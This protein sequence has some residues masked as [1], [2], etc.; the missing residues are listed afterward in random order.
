MK[1]KH[2]LL[3]VFVLL[4][5]SLFL[6]AQTQKARKISEKDLPEIYR[7]WLK[8][9]SYI[10]LPVEKEVF[11]KL[12]SDR[13]R[14]IFIET[15]WK[16]RDPTPGTPENEY[17]DEHFKRFAHANKFFGRSSTRE[18]WQTDMGRIHIILGT[19]VSIERFEATS[20]IVPCQAWSYYGNPEKDLPPHFVLLFYQ[21]GGA[22][23]YRLYDPVSD[24]PAALLL[25]KRDIDPLDYYELYEKIREIA[26]TLAD[27]SISIVP[28]EFNPDYTPSPRNNMIM[29]SIFES[30]RKDVN[31]TY[32]TH[33][34]SYKGIVSTEYMTNYVECDSN[35]SLIEDP[36]TGIP[37]VHFSMAP[38]SMSIDYYEPKDQYYC[39][40]RL[41]VSLRDGEK[42]ILQY[43]R[44]F[45]IY[46]TEKDTG[47]IQANGIAIEDSF[48]AA[49]GRHRLI[50]LLQNSVGKEFSLYEKDIVV[51]E[52]VGRPRLNGP[53]LGYKLE[54]YGAQ[55]HIP[56]K[57]QDKKLVVD[58]KNTFASGED[59]AILLNVID[60]S[61]EIWEK[62]EV[63]VEIRGLKTAGPQQ[64]LL[65]LKLRDSL[66][67]RIISLAHSLALSEL[68]PDYYELKLILMDGEGRAL[69]EAGGKFVVSPERA[70]PHPIASARGIP[71][72]NR[73]LFHH[74]LA[75][76]YD[77]LNIDDRAKAEYERVSSLS[78]EYKEAVIDYANF[79][80]KIKEFDLAATVNERVKGDEKLKFE[81]LLIRGKAQMGLGNYG[82]AIESFLE[83]NKIYNSDTRLLNS[84]GLCYYRTG[85][86]QRA[87]E[88]LG[89][90]LRLNPEQEEIKK[91]VKEIEKS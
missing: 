42:I 10:I 24:G 31:P 90:S 11:L 9:V 5:I 29:A 19:P 52:A 69:D 88:T 73:F 71:L 55:V 50:I 27:I 86:K 47:R 15:F 51:P 7:E 61:R 91:L 6:G 2:L 59:L 18:G 25:S 81:Y 17:R 1:K 44:D 83:G 84:L 16:Q 28:G 57:I 70:L 89:S 36:A 67:G 4:L 87:L 66:Y 14:D 21:R 60:S 40:F 62:G 74:M 48:P 65:V 80:L 77:L 85:E 39:S 8:L 13:D 30:P 75:R 79:L 64:K 78:P 23:D 20:H 26:P 46:F 43:N 53:F 63:R 34:L 35:V 41:D 56:Y 38:K 68:A 72:S 76:Q 37:F 82:Q 12:A 32:A 45:P 49:V 54:K 3:P 22:G 33:F 58:P